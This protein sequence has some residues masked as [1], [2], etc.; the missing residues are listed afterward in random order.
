[1]IIFPYCVKIT[2]YIM[3]KPC[4]L[5]RL[6]LFRIESIILEITLT[7]FNQIDH[8]IRSDPFLVSQCSGWL[9]ASVPHPSSHAPMVI[10]WFVRILCPLT[11]AHSMSTPISQHWW[12][13]HN[14]R[15]LFSIFLFLN[16]ITHFVPCGNEQCSRTCVFAHLWAC[17]KKY[18]FSV[19][20]FIRFKEKNA[21][22]VYQK[23]YSIYL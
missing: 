16:T 1:M 14:C 2:G 5:S 11:G 23:V 3:M 18:T 20:L 6:L 19:S 10:F 4:L 15:L 9:G 17:Q 13:S 7:S 22:E 8:T 12:V 21:F